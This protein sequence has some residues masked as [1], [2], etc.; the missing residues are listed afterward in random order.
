LEVKK[1]II[2]KNSIKLLLTGV[3]SALCAGIL[4]AQDSWQSQLL[5]V[6]GDGA[7][8]YIQNADGF[9]L[10]DFS[11]AGYRN[12]EPVP[13]IDMPDRT[14]TISPLPDVAA[15]NTAHI[16]AAI[17]KV[18]ARTNITTEKVMPGDYSFSVADAG[19][20]KV[21]YLICVKYPTTTAWLEAVWH[22]GNSKR[23]TDESMKWKTS[24]VDMSYHRY[25]KKIEGNVV[26]LDAPLYYTL[27]KTYAQAYIR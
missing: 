3:V 22:G 26:T 17:N 18:S 24:D 13:I 5:K 7:L 11:Q 6:A 27:D 14:E 4:R 19:A 10:P 16:Q 2:M 15:D 23:N 8:T 25:I 20:Y 12:G 21:G 9:V 1:I